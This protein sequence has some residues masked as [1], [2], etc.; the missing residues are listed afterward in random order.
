MKI[1]RKIKKK[2]K[3]QGIFYF[4]IFFEFFIIILIKNKGNNKKIKN[5]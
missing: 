4:L 3:N 2:V 5:K 1:L